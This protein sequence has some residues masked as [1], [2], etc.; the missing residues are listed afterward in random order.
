MN[1]G[2]LREANTYG[3]RSDTVSLA[4]VVDHR[5][6]QMRDQIHTWQATVD[7]EALVF[8][9][10]PRHRPARERRP[11]RR[12]QARLLD[13][14]G[15]DPPVGTAR[16][17]RHPHLPAG[18]GRDDRR[19]AVVGVRRTE[20]SPMPS[21]RRTASTRWCATA[22]GPSPARATA[23]SRCGPGVRPTWRTYDPAVHPTL[24]MEQPYDLVAEGGPDNVWIVEVG[25]ADEAGSFEEFMTG[26]R[27]VGARGRAR[28]RGLHRGV[29]LADVR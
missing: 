25:D 15:L 6:G 10:H 11:G 19:P 7:P 13:R 21:C 17:H 8:T 9:T 29:D 22:T 1:F 28:R 18:L 20:T 27:R 2:H 16:A 3:W 14:R 23:T 4:T 12:R 5:F 26:D 24:G